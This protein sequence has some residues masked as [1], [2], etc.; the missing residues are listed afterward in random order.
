MNGIA[1]NRAVQQF[2]A[3]SARAHPAAGR[4]DQSHD[5]VDIGI[6]GKRARP[7]KCLRDQSGNRG[8]TI[9]RGQDADIITRSRLAACAPIALERCTLRLRDIVGWMRIDTGRAVPFEP[10]ICSVGSVD[11]IAC[12]D[13]GRGKGYRLVEFRDWPAIRDRPGRDLVPGGDILIRHKPFAIEAGALCD[14]D[15]RNHH[16]VLFV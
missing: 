4:V 10:A 16:I 5:T 13:V 11:M 9:H 7:M 8:R 2:M 6:I 1:G 15:A 3:F 12:G 14:G